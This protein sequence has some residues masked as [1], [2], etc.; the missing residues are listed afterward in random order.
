MSKYYD[1]KPTV[2]NHHSSLSASLVADIILYIRMHDHSN[3]NP[4]IVFGLTICHF[5][6]NHITNPQSSTKQSKP[7]WSSLATIVSRRPQ[8][9]FTNALPTASAQIKIDQIH[10]KWVHKACCASTANWITTSKLRR[11]F[12]SPAKRIGLLR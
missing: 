5:R 7:S 8:I 11:A 10:A 12:V 3:R 9:N 2:R 6:R 4:I 1:S